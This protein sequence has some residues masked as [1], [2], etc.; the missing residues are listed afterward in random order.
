MLS[1]GVLLITLNEALNN[2][3][4]ETTPVTKKKSG[5]KPKQLVDIPVPHICVGRD[6]K[7]VD[8]KQ[9]FQLAALGCKDTEI[10]DW[11]GVDGNTLRYNFSVELLKGRES[12]KQSLRQAQIK[13]ALSGNAT[14]LI[15]LSKQFLGQ[16]DNPLNADDDK[17]LP[18]EMALTDKDE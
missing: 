7:A 3:T 17:I 1:W 8:P 11:I 12:L 10:C 14:M 4:S 15:W 9:I 13:L 18:W 5:P 6:K 2:M 16:S